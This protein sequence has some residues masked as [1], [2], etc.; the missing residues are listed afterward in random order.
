[1]SSR[2]YRRSTTCELYT[3]AAAKTEAYPTVNDSDGG[4][5]G[6]DRRLSFA[7]RP[8]PFFVLISSISSRF[9]ADSKARSFRYSSSQF[10][11]VR[12]EIGKE[13]GGSGCKAFAAPAEAV[14]NE[15]RL[16]PRR[17][18]S[19]RRNEKKDRGAQYVPDDMEQDRTSGRGQAPPLQGEQHQRSPWGAPL[20]KNSPGFP[21]GSSPRMPCRPN[22]N[23]HERAGGSPKFC[24]AASNVRQ[25]SGGL[26]SADS[27]RHPL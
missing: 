5:Y 13:D 14:R 25:E 4:E 8:A 15:L 1:M 16:T 22:Y 9:L 3:I 7:T 27:N 26:Q 2:L 18:L 21:R 6:F 23:L 17:Y 19:F 24:F 20:N 10:Q 11:S 12:F